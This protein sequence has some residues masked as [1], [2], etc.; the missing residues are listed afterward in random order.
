MDSDQVDV[1][2]E[3]FDES[4]TKV[5]TGIFVLS[6]STDPELPD[7]Y[8]WQYDPSKFTKMS[9]VTPDTEI[10]KLKI[11]LDGNKSP[12]PP[13]TYTIKMVIKNTNHAP[14]LKST[15]QLWKTGW[16]VGEALSTIEINLSDFEDID[17][18]TYE[19]VECVFTDPKN[20]KLDP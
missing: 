11:S 20:L 9:T 10:Y 16:T 7:T 13:N 6:K 1:T 15:A 17:G 2:Y 8:I 5:T 18:D 12:L 4:D 3:V 14:S 19:F